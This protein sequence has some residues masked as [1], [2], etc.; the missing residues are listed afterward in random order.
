MF[1]LKDFEDPSATLRN[2]EDLDDDPELILDSMPRYAS[3]VI[4]N[5]EFTPSNTSHLITEDSQTYQ[6]NA[7]SATTENIPGLEKEM[8]VDE[9]DK[10]DMEWQPEAA[11]ANETMHHRQD[12]LEKD[13]QAVRDLIRFSP[14]PQFVENQVSAKQDNKIAYWQKV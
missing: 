10:K 13:D 6:Y 2:E 12:L 9:E 14:T 11:G 1:V 8:A 5:T 4:S 3:P 7:M